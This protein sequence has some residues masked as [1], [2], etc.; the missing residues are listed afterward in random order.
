MKTIEQLTR[1]IEALERK[2]N[3]LDRMAAYTGV[4][5][6][7]LSIAIFIHWLAV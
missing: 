4:A 2:A 7:C 5:L 6:F 1:D 3:D